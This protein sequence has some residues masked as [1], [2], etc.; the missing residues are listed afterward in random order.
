[1][2]NWAVIGWMMVCLWGCTPA[3]EQFD[4]SVFREKLDLIK[5]TSKKAGR[6]AALRQLQD[7]LRTGSLSPALARLIRYDFDRDWNNRA[8]NYA[9]ELAFADSVI[10]ELRMSFAE[11][12]D[13]HRQMAIICRQR[14]NAYIQLGRSDEAAASIQEGLREVPFIA[15]T[16]A[17]GMIEIQGYSSLAYARFVVGRYDQAITFYHRALVDYPSCRFDSEGEFKR[18]NLRNNAGM[19]YIAKGNADSAQAEFRLAFDEIRRYGQLFPDKQY[20]VNSAYGVVCS[21]LADVMMQLGRLDSAAALLRSSVQ[22]NQWH[23]PE[24]A[25]LSRIKL[26]DVSVRKADLGAAGELKRTIRAALD[27]TRSAEAERRFARVSAAYFA[28]AGDT[29]QAFRQQVRYDS[30]VSSAAQKQSEGRESD[31]LQALELAASRNKVTLLEKENSIQHLILILGVVG[32]ISVVLIGTIITIYSLRLRTRNRE[33]VLINEQLSSVLSNLKN[34]IQTQ[35]RMMQVVAHDL[36]NPLTA[37]RQI[38]EAGYSE[39]GSE[40]FQAVANSARE[41][42]AIIENMV[43]ADNAPLNRQPTDLMSIVVPCVRMM[44]VKADEKQL[45]LTL[46]GAEHAL[47]RIDANGIWRV[48]TNLLSNAIKFSH[49]GAGIRISIEDDATE[50]RLSVKDTGIGIPTDKREEIF[51]FHT[52]MSRPGTEGEE[53]NGMGLAISRRIVERHD[54]KIEVESAPGLGSVFVVILPKA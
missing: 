6:D 27:T 31:L 35:N 8:G 43:K 48:L 19:A 3:K 25:L 44:Q 4:F 49:R 52:G 33:I 47:C 20:N 21:N 32:I 11:E 50:V 26:M 14:G 39:S 10:K 15:D 34:S 54:G 7:T 13:F 46:S 17:Q 12:G 38:S 1:M 42:A 23:E 37:I 51:D 24:N 5:D 18:Q 40:R 16:C 28:A 29:R 22:L 45:T 36:R 9:A 41:A 30:L 2:K 53:S